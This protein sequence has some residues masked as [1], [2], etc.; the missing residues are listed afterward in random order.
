MVT[1]QAT[2]TKLFEFLSN[3][4]TSLKLQHL[5]IGPDVE[6]YCDVRTE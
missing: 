2:N 1:E 3:P 4:D 5:Q 6:L